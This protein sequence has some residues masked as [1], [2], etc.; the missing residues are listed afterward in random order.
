MDAKSFEIQM[1]NLANAID[2]IVVN[3]E[4][5]ASV[6]LI[7]LMKRRI[8]NDG[9]MTDGTRIGSYHSMYW[10]RVR[11]SFGRQTAYKDLQ[12]SG[13]L[14]SSFQFGRIG[15]SIAIGFLATLYDASYG[16][17]RVP[18]GTR[19]PAYRLPIVKAYTVARKQELAAGGAIFSPSVGEVDAY[20][21][22]IQKAIVAALDRY[23]K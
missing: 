1:R 23:L 5:E 4:I 2:S 12:H 9:I 10:R 11:S 6:N 13:Q 14:I 20:R 18:K 7:S 17:W 16:R 21:E 15:D 3:A 8:F 22:S 19:V